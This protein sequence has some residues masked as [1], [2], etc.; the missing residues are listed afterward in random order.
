MNL[1]VRVPRLRLPYVPE[2]YH[3]RIYAMLAWLVAAVFWVWLV[4]YLLVE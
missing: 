2:C 1:I 4:S 3:R